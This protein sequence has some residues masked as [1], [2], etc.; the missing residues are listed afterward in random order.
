MKKIS[1]LLV[2]V[3]LTI[4]IFF[5]GPAEAE[6]DFW[7]NEAFSV[8]V[9]GSGGG[10]REDNV[11]G[12]MVW[13]VERTDEAI[14][15]DPGVLTVGIRKAD[16]MNNLWDF[17]VPQDSDLT[18]EGWIMQN[19]KAYLISH[20]HLDHINAM[21]LNSP[22]DSS[23]DIIGTDTTI[24]Y[25]KENIFN[26]EIWPNLTDGGPKPNLGQYSYVNVNHGEKITINKTSMEVQAFEVMHDP[27]TKSTAFLL[28]DNNNY[29]LFF[30]DV[31]P[32]K[33][34]ETD[35]LN[36]IWQ[37]IAPLIRKDQLKGIFLEVSYPSDRADDLLFGHLT[38]KW[39]I[40]ELNQLA[41]IVDPDNF[42]KALADLK[43]VVTHIKPAFNNKVPPAQRIEKELNEMN[44]LG[45][46]FIIPAQ[47]DRY[48]F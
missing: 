21:V 36:N 11:S 42:E 16:E 27:P 6:E 13:P 33:I 38:P 48:N 20:A 31:G 7:T 14:V 12:Y 1:V 44:N 3:L 22:A 35:H 30:G 18:R 47:G 5:S 2:F 17:K 37:D 39:M 29:L 32:D 26:W 9:L 15:F 43:V 24:G 23:K 45:I 40:E 46:D 4:P 8:V 19:S 41:K 10:P 25:L 34:Q 28:E